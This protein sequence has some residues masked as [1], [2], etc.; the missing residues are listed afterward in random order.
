MFADPARREGLFALIALNVELSR[1]PETVSEPMLGEIR[2]QWWND[3]INALFD[4][5]RREGHEV[6]SALAQPIADGRLE[7]D[8]LID[9]IDARRL[10]LS[11]APFG[12]VEILRK[13]IEQTG[14]A[15][16]ALQVG[17]L[18]ADRAAQDV[19]AE[20]GWAEGAGR[21]I[22]ALPAMVGDQIDETN[23]RSG[24]APEALAQ[25]SKSLANEGLKRLGSARQSRAAIPR[26]CRAWGS[27]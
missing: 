24:E 9:L 19:A 2:L 10:I 22:S 17:A 25:L 27:I 1:I 6:I 26:R 11:D 21:L 15:L 18:G 5:G 4:G 13:L 14:G 3:A 20:V 8:R 16:A 12:Q 7:K 23:V